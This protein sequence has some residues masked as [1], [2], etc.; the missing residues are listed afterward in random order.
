MYQT[1]FRQ[2][3]TKIFQIFGVPIDNAKTKRKLKFHL[4][5]PVMKYL[6]KTFNSCCWSSLESAFHCIND[7]RS[8]LDPVNIIG[9]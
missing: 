3:D 7:S 5:A 2:D 8:V 4:A 9:K 6:Q 1:K